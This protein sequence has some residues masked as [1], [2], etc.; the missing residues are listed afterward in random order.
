[1]NSYWRSVLTCVCVY[2]TS[3]GIASTFLS[4]LMV[5]GEV[6]LVCLAAPDVSSAVFFYAL[7]DSMGR[8]G[9]LGV[10]GVLLTMAGATGFTYGVTMGDD[11]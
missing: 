3:V 4:A 7:T 10:L 5:F 9:F 2:L 1:M 8:W 11:R 6:A